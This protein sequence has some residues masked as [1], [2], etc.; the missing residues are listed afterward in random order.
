MKRNLTSIVF[1]LIVLALICFGVFYPPE[2]GDTIHLGQR[3]DPAD[4]SGGIF[5]VWEAKHAIQKGRIITP[6]DF[7]VAERPQFSVPPGAV[8]LWL[9]RIEWRASI[10]IK[11]GQIILEEYLEPKD[12]KKLKEYLKEKFV[13]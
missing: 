5:E 10:D 6:K 1:L 12:P 8:K 13:E 7:K 11:K 4:D 9:K 3:E 2:A